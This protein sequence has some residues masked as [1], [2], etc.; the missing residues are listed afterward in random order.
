MR[1]PRQED[2]SRRGFTLVE[3]LVVIAVIGILVALLLPALNKA[4]RAA[5]AVACLSNLRQIGVA[6]LAYASANKEGLLA[7]GV[8]AANTYEAQLRNAQDISY[9]PTRVQG[10]AL[11]VEQ[12]YLSPR[13]LYC[14]GRDD[15]NGQRFTYDAYLTGWRYDGWREMGYQVAHSADMRVFGVKDYRLWYKLGRT[16]PEQVIAYDICYT[17]SLIIN[18]IFGGPSVPYGWSMHGHGK[19]Y[20]MAFMD[21]SAR[22]VPDPSNVLE[23]MWAG[24]FLSNNFGHR[25]MMTMLLGWSTAR[26]DADCP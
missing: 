8:P 24:T 2:R 10:V 18:G 4:R 16:S 5:R 15:S 14:P 19:G 17:D 11:L 7:S 6:E 12:K 20:N 26:Y 25:Q 21:G 23:P 22:F 9:V 13:V 1:I 3:L